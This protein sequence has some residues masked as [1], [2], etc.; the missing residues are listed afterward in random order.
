MQGVSYQALVYLLPA[1]VLIIPLLARRYPGERRLVALASTR[2]PRRPRAGAR[3]TSYARILLSVPR[4]G[5]L[6]ASSLAV[7]PPPAP[8]AVP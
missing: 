7:R 1:L 5:Q 4:G 2:R 8:A 3:L 6:I